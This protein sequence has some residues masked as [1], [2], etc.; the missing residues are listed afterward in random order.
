MSRATQ[1]TTEASEGSHIR[2][3]HPLWPFFPKRSI[4]L[5]FM[6]NRR[7]P[8]TPVMPTTI[9][10]WANARSLATTCAITFVFFSYGYL[11]VSVPHVRLPCGM[12]GLQPA[13]L[14]HSDIRGSR[15]I[16][17]YPRL[18][19][20][21]HVLRRLREPRHPP[22]ALSYFLYFIPVCLS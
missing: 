21:Y 13:G 12:A 4:S 2:G 3:C 6:P 9:R 5:L 18:F 16:C 19:A 17:T 8:T 14:P 10:V 22:S 15:V 7:S 1:D 11:D 20:A